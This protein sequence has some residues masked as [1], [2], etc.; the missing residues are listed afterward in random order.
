M[1]VCVCTRTQ[2]CVVL[3]VGVDRYIP[4]TMLVDVCQCC[5]LHACF[6]SRHFPCC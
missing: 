1:C 3:V 5:R 6:I 2:V 4:L